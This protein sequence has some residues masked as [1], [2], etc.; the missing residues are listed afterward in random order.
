MSGQEIQLVEASKSD[1][2]I[3]VDLERKVSGQK[4]YAPILDRDEMLA[5]FEKNKMF[6]IQRDGS[7]VGTIMYEFKKPNHVYISG[8]VIDPDFQ[9]QGIGRAAMIKLLDSLKSVNRIDMV[10]H[11]DNAAALSLY[12][13]LGFLVESR[14]ENYFGDGEPRLILVKQQ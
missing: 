6:I 1:V 8:L 11:P 4:I 12:D 5:E 9:R 7:A 14:K 3:F 2:D 13:S 10:T